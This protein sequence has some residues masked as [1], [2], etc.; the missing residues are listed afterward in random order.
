MRWNDNLVIPKGSSRLD[1][2]HKLLNYWYDVTAATTLSEYIGYFTPVKGVD[3]QISADAQAARD[4]GD[5]E[6][7]DLY[8]T[9]APT[10]VPTEDQISNTYP[11]KEMTEE[12]EAEWND[13]FEG[14]L[15]A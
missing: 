8:D 3:E 2:A 11:D 6:T 13:L 1:D 14:V 7:A 15:G 12:E 5:T 10:V 4:D 9:L